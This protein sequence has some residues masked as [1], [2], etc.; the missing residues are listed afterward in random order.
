M[1]K[2]IC[3]I[4]KNKIKIIFDQ[5]DDDGYYSTEYNL[6]YQRKIKIYKGVDNILEF[7]VKKANQKSADISSYKPVITFF[8][9]NQNFLFEKNG[10]INDDK[11]GLFSVIVTEEDLYDIRQ[12]FVYF[13]V[14]MTSTNEHII[15]Y[16][17]S[18]FGVRGQAE[19]YNDSMPLPK[20]TKIINS[21]FEGSGKLTSSSLDLADINLGSSVLYTLAFYP[22]TY[23]GT[24][25]VLSTLDN[26]VNLG[27]NWV[28]LESFEITSK[29][30]KNYTGLFKFFKIELNINSGT[31]DKILVR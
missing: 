30:Y 22:G 4:L 26:N 16:T 3:Y 31:F 24:V 14:Q 27:T 23:T 7:D 10:K 18:N 5:F 25:K 11:D 19:I 21:F 13:T 1:Q 28:E 17:D 12:Q 9:S 8:D 29:I 20:E 6:M 15:C 2:V